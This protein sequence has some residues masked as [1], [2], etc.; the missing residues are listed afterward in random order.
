MY[1]YDIGL[2][3]GAKFSERPFVIASVAVLSALYL[4]PR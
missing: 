4:T 1:G 3:E 2:N